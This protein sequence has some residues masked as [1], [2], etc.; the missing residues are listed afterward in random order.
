MKKVYI[1]STSV[2][3]HSQALAWALRKFSVSAQVIA[4]SDLPD[5]STSSWS[6][7]GSSWIDQN[8]D[9]TPE[10]ADLLYL[11]RI[12]PAKA[13]DYAHPEDL[14]FIEAS[15]NKFTKWLIEYYGAVNHRWIQTPQACRA[16]N[17]KLLQLTTAKK[18]G[19]R[20]PDTL[21]SNNFSEVCNF[22]NGRKR[23]IAKPIVAENWLVDGVPKFSFTA[24]VQSADLDE[25][26]VKLAPM[27]Y[28]SLV[29][30]TAEYRV[31]VFG[32]DIISAK[33]NPNLYKETKIDWRAAMG[34][35]LDIQKSEL[36]ETTIKKL[37]Q[38]LK[39]MNLKT[40]VF[41]LVETTDGEIV[42]LEVNES[43]QFL[44]LEGENPE[45]KSL[46]SATRFFLSLISVPCTPAIAETIS[47][48]SFYKEN[49]PEMF[50]AEGV[51]IH[52]TEPYANRMQTAPPS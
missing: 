47:L 38:F 20:V 37:K 3:V 25:D 39:Q 45:I 31:A 16:A 33:L 13:P 6:P 27:I 17:N 9:I 35:T 22:V 5:Y 49:P 10:D 50:S 8:A 7:H 23:C 21:V 24:E 43:G 28:Q 40:G 1:Y 41:D 19:L 51:G 2:D 4:L 36:N 15:C 34:H 42:F 12:W 26:A 32:D 11:R 18:I 46:L 14:E 44:F 52:K 48:D 30:K 29:E